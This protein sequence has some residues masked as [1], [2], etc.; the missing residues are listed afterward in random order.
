MAH[1]AGIAHY[2]NGFGSPQ[3]PL[4]EINNE[5]INTGMEWALKYLTP[6]PLAAPVDYSYNYTTFGFNLAGV[7]IEKAVN[8]SFEN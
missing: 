7:V 6:M 8:E 3:P 5:K 1:Y 2:D 4:N